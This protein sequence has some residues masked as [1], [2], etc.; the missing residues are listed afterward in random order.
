[1]GKISSQLDIYIQCLDT[2]NAILQYHR[3][4]RHDSPAL[5]CEYIHISNITLHNNLS[6]RVKQ[7]GCCILEGQH[8]IGVRGIPGMRPY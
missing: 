2:Y 6:L 4:T 7:A 3:D 5:H 8:Y 1:M